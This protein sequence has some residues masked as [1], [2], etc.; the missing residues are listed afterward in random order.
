MTVR[1]SKPKF[2]LREKLSELDV[3]VGSHGGRIIQSSNAEETFSLVKAGRRN[4]VINGQM[5]INQR[6]ASSSYTI[7][8]ATGGSY[9][10]PDRWAINEAT[11]GSVSVNMDGDPP[12]Y[13]EVSMFTKAMQIACTGTDTS[14]AS[15][16]NLHFFQNI[17]GHN[18]AHLGW[19][20]RNAKPVTLSFWVKTNHAGYYSVG[21]ENNG[22]DRCCIRQ[23]YNNGSSKWQ[24]YVLTYPGCGTGSWPN[25]TATGI[26]LR[27][28]LAS[29]AQYD[30]GAEGQ[31]VTTD[32]LVIG[33]NQTNFMVSTSNRFFITG[34][35]LE[36]GTEA[37]PFEQR[38]I[39]E[40]LAYCQRYYWKPFP[41]NNSTTF[42]QVMIAMKVA[43]TDG[44]RAA[45]TFFPVMMRAAPSVV[46]EDRAGDYGGTTT[47][48]RVTC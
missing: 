16:Q 30:D 33:E 44:G 28:C 41:G 39:T 24:K 32:E 45:S 38:S 6:N 20:T 26:R 8:H 2:N 27:F 9:G 43:D 4:M 47:A 5:W 13:P 36:E 11:D 34:V 46:F 23:F 25:G 42:D 1:V 21:L 29:G 48:Q 35:Q 12:N 7:P 40:E 14:L 3:P 10:G 18:I 17:E 15:T 37:T 19:G 31:W 22:V